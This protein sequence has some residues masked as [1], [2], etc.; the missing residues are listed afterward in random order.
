MESYTKLHSL[1]CSVYS[2]EH[3]NI[4]IPGSDIIIRN[5][6]FIS[7]YSDISFLDTGD[8]Q[9]CENSLFSY[10][11]F[12]PADRSSRKVIILLHGL[13]ER[14]WTKYLPWAFTLANNTCSYVILFPISF[15]INRSPEAWKNP[16]EM[17]NVLT[18]RNSAYGR[19]EMSSFANVALSERL[20]ENPLRFFSSGYQTSRDLLKL[21]ESIRG[22]NH[23]LIPGT[24]SVNIFAYSIGAFLA[25]IMF[26]GNPDGVMD[27]SK[28][29]IFCG[30]SVFS[31]MNGTSKFIMDKKA[32]ESLNDFY[33]NNLDSTIRTKRNFADFLNFDALGRAFRAMLDIRYLKD[34]REKSFRGFRKNLH[35]MALL[36][37]K[38][39]PPSGILE[40]LSSWNSEM[41]N[42][43]EVRDFPYKYSH[44]NPFPLFN[45]PLSEQV[46]LCF[47]QV[48]SRAS[49]FLG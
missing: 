45:S 24:R 13:N 35:A 8:L 20:T 1:L 3:N 27:H 38:V 14:S 11:V 48:F 46:D 41:K 22:G 30:G 36:N 49:Q 10:P 25:E 26:I 44:E 5:L 42:V 28:L 12:I 34:I 2:T 29:F 7:D 32:Y 16:R 43:A 4:E 40:T 37:D 6:Q 47:N 17:S 19:I 23:N 15:H 18:R 39:I 33:L 9:I 31:N 21:M